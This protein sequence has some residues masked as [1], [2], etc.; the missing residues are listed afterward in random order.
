MATNT[1]TALATIEP[2]TILDIKDS[3]KELA[4][5]EN[6]QMEK[7]AKAFAAGLPDA[8]LDYIWNATL[9]NLQRKVEAYGIDIFVA[10][11]DGKNIGLRPNEDSLVDRW[12]RVDAFDVLTG[13]GRIGLISRKGLKAL[14]LI[15][16]LRN[17]ASA[18][19]STDEE[20]DEQDL[21][22]AFVT[23]TK[24]VFSKPLPQPAFDFKSVIE[25]LKT[26]DLSDDEARCK[27]IFGGFNRRDASTCLGMLVSLWLDDDPIGRQNAV[28]IIPIVWPLASEQARQAVGQ[29]Y[30][31]FHFEVQLSSDAAPQD[32]AERVLEIL[33]LVD[34]LR[35]I[36]DHLRLDMYRALAARLAQ[37]KDSFFGWEREIG[38]A[39][40]IME[41]GETAIPEDASAELSSPIIRVWCGNTWGR[42]TAYYHLQPL[43]DSL[44][45]SQIQLWLELMAG[46]REVQEEFTDDGP[47]KRALQLIG[48]LRDQTETKKVRNYALA[49]AKK[50]KTLLGK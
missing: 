11:F 31:E 6:K 34:G 17:H 13:C 42:S 3:Y 33:K 44:T 19:H 41:L 2:Q 35:Y 22:I 28:A 7:A 5:S 25:P 8:A 40:E 15:N 46:D 26:T 27:K 39:K 10:S 50:V 20:V 45:D 36:P 48:E 30:F 12:E 43:K 18:A 4:P 14:E 49:V 9:H 21:Q 32:A 23:V 37:A 29:K 38:V 16:W 24:E 47:N 1:T